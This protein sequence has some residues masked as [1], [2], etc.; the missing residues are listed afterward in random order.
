MTST[1]VRLDTDGPVATITLAN[2]QKRNA[3]SL[4]TLHE[5]TDAIH[6][7]PDDAR[8]VVLA[9]EGPVFSAGHD[10]GEMIDRPAAF[11]D[12]L[13][14]DCTTMMESL[15]RIPQPVIAKV[16][17][18]ATAAGC[19]LVAS[20]DLAVAAEEAWFATPGVRIG[21]F[22]TTPM[23]P[24][25]RS[26]GRKRA[27]Q[28]LL[29]GEPV[30][31]HTAAEWG[32]VNTVVPVDELDKAVDELVATILRWS[33]ETIAIGKRAFYAQVDLPEPAAYEV[34]QPIMAQN[35]A[36]P[37]AQ[38]GMSAFLEKRPPMWKGLS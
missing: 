25:V 13:F 30:D 23:V 17:G 15:H 38:E 4:E 31:A 26:I 3:L 21:L 32:L 24:I 8:V 37:D 20:C 6:A 36:I 10:L 18:P 11:Y 2:P 12:R 33:A 5:L 16:Q 7:V 9:A 34:A 19:Q 35:A 1:T 22:C 27:M 28:M 14:A 29:T